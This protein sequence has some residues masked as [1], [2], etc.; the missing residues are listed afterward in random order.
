MI[1]MFGNY[2]LFALPKNESD[3]AITTNGIVK[4]DGSAVMGAGIARYARE[5]FRDIDTLLGDKLQSSGNHAFDLGVW[6][7]ENRKM[8]LV[9]LPTKNNWGIQMI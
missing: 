1:E 6:E 8:R 5:H 3:A 2:N 9:S 7:F 4:K